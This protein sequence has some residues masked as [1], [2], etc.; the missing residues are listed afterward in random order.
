MKK[1]FCLFLCAVMLLSL[2]SCTQASASLMSWSEETQDMIKRDF[3]RYE[4]SFLDLNCTS[5]DVFID[6]YYGTYQDNALALRITTS[7]LIGT[8]DRH[9][10]EI[11][12]F[13]FSYNDYNPFFIYYKR[14]F[15]PLKEAY[16]NGMVSKEDVEKIH[17]LYNLGMDKDLYDSI[18]QDYAKNSNE[19]NKADDVVIEDF[20]GIYQDNAAAIYL[21]ESNYSMNTE[22]D[23]AGVHFKF[24]DS[25]PIYIYREG[26]FTPLKKAYN[27]GIVSKE[28]VLS[29]HEIYE[30]SEYYERCF[31]E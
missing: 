13:L 11:A 16:E 23:I 4:N 6:N 24:S 14:T 31:G 25:R 15:T 12:G 26:V 28:D 3:A 20:Y 2:C 5:E 10:D 22:E 8:F 17:E 1:L 7:C 21:V 27:E 18:R 9:E 19:Y 29:I 30:R